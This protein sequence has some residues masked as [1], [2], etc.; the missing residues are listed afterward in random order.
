MRDKKADDSMMHEIKVTINHL[1][2]FCSD[3]VWPLLDYLLE[4]LLSS[5]YG[6][7]GIE[8]CSLDLFSRAYSIRLGFDRAC[9]VDSAFW[10]RSIDQRN[11]FDQT[12]ITDAVVFLIGK[13]TRVTG[14]EFRSSVM[15]VYA[16]WP[17]L[18]VLTS[19]YV[20]IRRGAM[21]DPDFEISTN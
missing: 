2:I 7:S 13:A 21:D 14:F 4:N 3:C 10:I 1:R 16:M 9:N 18:D 15:S 17:S 8:F 19:M 20:R 6:K 12:A 11:Y 5:F